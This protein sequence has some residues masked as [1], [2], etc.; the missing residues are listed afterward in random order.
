M[1]TGYT[2]SITSETTFSQFAMNCARGFGACISLRD[3][4]SGGELIPGEFEPSSYHKEQLIEKERAL[5]NVE[6]MTM[7]QCSIASALEHKNLEQSRTESLK[8]CAVLRTKYEAMLVKVNNWTPPTEEH[9]RLKSFMVEQLESSIRF[10]CSEEYYSKPTE[11]L[12][13]EEWKMEQISRIKSSIIYHSESHAKEIEST[14]QRNAWIKA[15]RGS[16][17]AYSATSP[18]K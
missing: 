5:K 2:A 18:E 9:N 14:A 3:E 8:N 6:V 11:K 13:V 10:D 1:P 15:L 12:T 4:E 7:E 17:Q 16:L